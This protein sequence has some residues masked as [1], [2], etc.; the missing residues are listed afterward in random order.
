MLCPDGLGAE[1]RK[2]EKRWS[3]MSPEVVAPKDAS[4]ETREPLSARIL[5]RAKWGGGRLQGTLFPRGL[6]LR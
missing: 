6:E 3:S 2:R 1:G 5:W 4:Q